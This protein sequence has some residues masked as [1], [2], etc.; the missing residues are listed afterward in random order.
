MVIIYIAIIIMMNYV[1]I[2]DSNTGEV[3]MMYM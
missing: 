3:D 1:I 2:S